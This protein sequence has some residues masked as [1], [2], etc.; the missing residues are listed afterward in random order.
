MPHKSNFFS[1]LFFFFFFWGCESMK[2]PRLAPYSENALP[3][4]LCLTR[5]NSGWGG[6]WGGGGLFYFS[7]FRFA[8]F[9]FSSFI[10]FGGRGGRGLRSGYENVSLVVAFCLVFGGLFA[11]ERDATFYNHRRRGVLFLRGRK[12]TKGFVLRAASSSSSS[13]VAQA[14]TNL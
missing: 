2:V 9:V 6:G 10:L 13:S 1:F 12:K 14:K 5:T 3:I 8:R 7:P 11:C 4:G